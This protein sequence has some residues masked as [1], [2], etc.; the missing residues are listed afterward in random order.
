MGTVIGREGESTVQYTSRR[1]KGLK[2]LRR[3]IYGTHAAGQMSRWYVYDEYR[4]TQRNQSSY[5][6]ERKKVKKKKKK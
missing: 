3:K 4:S 2:I 1:K 5:L 6:Q